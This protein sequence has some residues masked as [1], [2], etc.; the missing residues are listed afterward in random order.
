M[1]ILKYEIDCACQIHRSSRKK[2]PPVSKSLKKTVG[3]RGVEM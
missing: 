2:N 3:D 1:I